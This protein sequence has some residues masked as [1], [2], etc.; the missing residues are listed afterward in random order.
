MGA[1]FPIAARWFVHSVGAAA[2]QAGSLYAAN[3][4]GAALG[5]LLAGFVLLPALGLLGATLVA[6]GL[7]VVAA[8]G[9]FGIASRQVPAPAGD[10]RPASEVNPARHE[11]L[12][13]FAAGGA[14]S[15]E[16]A[17]R[18]RDHRATPD[19][20]R[21]RGAGHL[22]LRVADPPGRLDASAG[23]HPRTDHLRVQPHRLDFH[24]RPRRGGG[25]R[26]SP[27]PSCAPT[28]RGA[29]R[30]SRVVRRPRRGVRLTHR[31][32]VALDRG[33]GRPAR[34]HLRRCPD[35]AG[36]ARRRPAR[37]DDDCV[38]RRV[39][40][41]GVRRD[42]AGR[43]HRGGPGPDLRRQHRGRD[44]GCTAVRIC[45]DSGP[46]SAR[47]LAGGRRRGSGRRAGGAGC[48]IHR[49]VAS[50]GRGDV[51]GRRAGLWP[52]AAAVGSAA[53]VERR[54]QVCR[55]A[56]GPGSAH[57]AQRGRTALLPRGRERH[58]RGPADR[59]A[60]PPSPSTAKWTPPTRAT[61]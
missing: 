37:A 49:R 24:R 41:R 27:R 39:S 12:V 61:C 11:R 58:R 8:A 50:S 53:A 23:A 18:P 32:R 15:G 14:S 6:V 60:R 54:V 52:G 36:P 9:A 20:H 22:G 26:L 40:L 34:R 59:G 25:H 56:P 30:L 19:R 45:A 47:H 29:R 21:R 38:R 46:W 55:G 33:S 28:P 5:A 3:T 43:H 13:R 42:A 2:R 48:R 16:G 51:L 1:T 17:E 35:A 7:N 31:S 57:G 10:A 44:R 4:I